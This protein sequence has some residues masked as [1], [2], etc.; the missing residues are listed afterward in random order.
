[1]TNGRNKRGSN[2]RERKEERINNCKRR[3]STEELI[4]KFKFPVSASSV[5]GA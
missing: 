2:K 4:N 3:Q 1:M 5:Y